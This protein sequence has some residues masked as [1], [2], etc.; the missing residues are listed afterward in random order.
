[1]DYWNGCAGAFVALQCRINKEQEPDFSLEA[2]TNEYGEFKFELP[3]SIFHSHEQVQRCSATL[4]KNPQG[5]CKVASMAKSSSFSL[6]SKQG[7][8]YTYSAGSFTYRPPSPP[9]LCSKDDVSQTE[10]L[11]SFKHKQRLK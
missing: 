2:Q 8:I 9:Q 7:S 10:T 6:K 4:L 5:S 3:P 11:S 1:L